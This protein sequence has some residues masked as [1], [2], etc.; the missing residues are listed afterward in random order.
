VELV[1]RK[2]LGHRARLKRLL[3]RGDIYY[4]ARAAELAV[5]FIETHI[6]HWKNPFAGK[7]FKL[8]EWQKNDIVKPLFGFK[9]KATGL[10]VFREAYIQLARKAGKSSLVAAI[11]LTLL[12]C[13]GAGSEIYCAAT[14]KDQARIVFEDC[15]KF[16]KNSPALKARAITRAL[17]IIVPNKDS[18]LKP[19]SADEQSLDGLNVAAA[20]IDELGKHR[21]SYVHDVIVTATGSRT[22]P[23]VI[24]ITTA[25]DNQTG[26][27]YVLYE[28]GERMLDGLS[29]DDPSFFYYVCEADAEDDWKSETAFR[30]AN[31][32]YPVTPNRDYFEKELKRA[33]ASPTYRPT[34]FK[35]SLNRWVGTAGVAW[36]DGEAWKR[37]AARYTEEDLWGNKIWLGIDL[38]K[39]TD[40]SAIVGVVEVTNYKLQI[41][42][43]NQEP[44]QL[45]PGLYLLAWNYL[46]Q[47]RIEEVDAKEAPYRAW[48][49]QGWVTPSGAN[50][51]DIDVLEEKIIEIGEHFEI[52]EVGVD[53]N[54]AGELIKR[55]E[56]GL[57]R[58][59]VL[60]AQSLI[61]FSEPSKELE[62]LILDG[63]IRHNDNPCLSWQMRQAKV[64]VVGDLIKPVKEYAAS[65]RRI[66]SVIG[67]I[68][69]L[70]VRMKG[71]EGPSVYEERGLLFI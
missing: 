32:N 18:T 22:Q 1:C 28:L 67:A 51:I 38:S 25:Q 61:V 41:T 63:A 55:I 69:A 40:L 33:L 12:F 14:K 59:V 30:K 36:I 15:K 11:L 21:T 53:R 13:G 37:C 5:W 31:P 49:E 54:R 20:S 10:R 8:S 35:Y 43:E 56:A 29:E 48:V 44:K 70:F 23:M 62:K 46:P 4:D 34:Y 6:R 39:T 16:V 24:N 42:N 64:K 50:S 60:V 19:L 58:E 2:V 68:M 45:E 71:S 66:D 52:Q 7:P 27:G 65:G 26:I 57:G 9:W 3:E 47:A 17:E